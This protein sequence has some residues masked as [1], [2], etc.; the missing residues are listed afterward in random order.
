M[1]EDQ[2]DEGYAFNFD[3]DTEEWML[4]G[5]ALRDAVELYANA[6]DGDRARAERDAIAAIRHR[7]ENGELWARAPRWQHSVTYEGV[8]DDPIIAKAMADQ[9]ERGD[10]DYALGPQF[11]WNYDQAERFAARE[12]EWVTSSVR[13]DWV[14]GDIEFEMRSEIAKGPMKAMTI[15]GHAYGLCF[16]RT[17]LPTTQ[18]IVAGKFRKP[19]PQ[20]DP[21]PPLPEAL[22]RSWWT[23]MTEADRAQPWSDLELMCKAMF[24]QHRIARDRVRA[25]DPGRK[26]GPKPICGNPS[27]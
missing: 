22:L 1:H 24:P 5:H 20:N 26:P 11:W 9:T 23:G 3:W 15:S 21:R 10:A 27:A 8:V 7:L 2:E 17:G 6:R 13:V 25:L 18:R 16:N 4:A 12:D 19:K 14:A